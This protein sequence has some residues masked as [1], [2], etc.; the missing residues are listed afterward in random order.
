VLVTGVLRRSG[1]AE[2]G[3]KLGDIIAKFD[4]QPVRDEKSI[5]EALALKVPGDPVTLT[6]LRDQDTIQL[7]ATL[8]AWE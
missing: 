5:F 8:G 2:A 4:D 3:V 6:I 1:A 7:E